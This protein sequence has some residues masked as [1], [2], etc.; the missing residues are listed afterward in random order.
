[1]KAFCWEY[2]F[3]IIVAALKVVSRSAKYLLP[4]KQTQ[5]STQQPKC[6]KIGII[7]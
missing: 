4:R 6:Q 7:F 3:C 5:A 2:Q 1:M